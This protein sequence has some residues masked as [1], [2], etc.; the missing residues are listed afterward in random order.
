MSTPG[1]ANNDYVAENSEI[2]ET[3]I[4]AVRNCVHCRTG[5]AVFEA[6]RLSE[7]ADE[8]GLCRFTSA[9]AF[10][11][12]LWN[13]AWRMRANGFGTAGER[14]VDSADMINE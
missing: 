13:K 4:C 11:C 14:H 9:K 3:G 12:Y 7:K 2:T 1:G 10:I 5:Q 8:S 6:V